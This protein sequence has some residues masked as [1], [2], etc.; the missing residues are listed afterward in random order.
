MT[1]HNW[2]HLGKTFN[3]E[4]IFECIECGFTVVSEF[5][6]RVVNAGASSYNPNPE[7]CDY[8]ILHRVLET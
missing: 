8:W 3:G 7:D 1:P 6:D 4:H 5:E 2:K